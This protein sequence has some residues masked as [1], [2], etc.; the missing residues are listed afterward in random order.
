MKCIRYIL[1]YGV[2]KLSSRKSL[3]TLSGHIN[4]TLGLLCRR[5]RFTSEIYGHLKYE[6][7]QHEDL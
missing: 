7:D 4:S 6:V 3:P 1:D 5:T 2:T